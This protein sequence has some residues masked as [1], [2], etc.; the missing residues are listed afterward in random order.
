MSLPR[1]QSKDPIMM[2]MQTQWA[3]QLDPVIVLPTNKGQILK[4]ISLVNGA[5][6]INHLLGRN[7]QGWFLV[8]QRGPAAIYDLQDLNQQPNLTLILHSDA[9]VV[10]DIFV[11]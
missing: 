8:R 5:N 6:V 7:L 9:N 11:F 10:V 4:K 3:E 1:F 2:Q